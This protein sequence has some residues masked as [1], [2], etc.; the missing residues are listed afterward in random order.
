MSASSDAP[1]LASRVCARA[2]PQLFGLAQA[3]HNGSPQSDAKEVDLKPT[4]GDRLA[5]REKEVVAGGRQHA[6]DD[7]G[8][9]KGKDPAVIMIGR[10]SL[11]RGE[12]HGMVI[13]GDV[14]APHKAENV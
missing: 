13:D 2:L 5:L 4:G 9:V 8:L 14:D 7:T 3:R 1:I 10:A 11:V 6:G 12:E